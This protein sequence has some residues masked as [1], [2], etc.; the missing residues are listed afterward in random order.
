MRSAL[1]LLT[2]SLSL[3]PAQ[4]PRNAPRDG[5]VVRYP[6][7]PAPHWNIQLVRNSRFSGRGALLERMR[8]ELMS[9]GLDDGRAGEHEQQLQARVPDVGIRLAR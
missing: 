9:A 2:S 5:S 8:D 7:T 6:A 4:S 1:D 3:D